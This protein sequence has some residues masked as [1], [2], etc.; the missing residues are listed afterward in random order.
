[1]ADKAFGIDALNILGT[2]TPTIESPNSLNINASNVAISTNVTLGGKIN[3]E[4]IIG[5]YNVG[6][7]TTI[8]TDAA[9]SN[10]TQILNVG[11]VTANHFYGGSFYGD[12]SNLSGVTDPTNTTPGIGIT[13]I[14]KLV[15][16]KSSGTDGGSVTTS[17]WFTRTLNTIKYDPYGIVTLSSDEFTLQ[18]GQYKITF[19]APAWGVDSHMS[20]L[21]NVTSGSVVDYGQNAYTDDN[22]YYAQTSSVGIAYTDIAAATT[23]KIDH[24]C[25]L[26]NSAADALGISGGNATHEIYTVVLIEKF[27]TRD[28]F[29][30]TTSNNTGNIG[31]GTTTDITISGEKAYSLFKIETSHASWV[32]LYIDT[33][34]RTN[35]STRKYT[36]DPAPGSGVLAEVYTTTSGISTFKMAPTVN[37]WNDDDPTPSTNIYAKVTNNESTSQDITVTLTILRTE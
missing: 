1:M 10:N 28:V 6:I 34:S 32:R 23:F 14:A 4:V 33:T 37:G 36:T 9:D 8:P 15:D 20:R 18:R 30:Y 12:G 17:N 11:I 3:S 25:V 2:G 16:Q 24:R 13:A 21:Y 29:R 22:T 19:S 35:D 26:S 5:P 7:G 31:A 27:N